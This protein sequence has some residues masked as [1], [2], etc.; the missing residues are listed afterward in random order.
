MCGDER[1]PSHGASLVAQPAS[2]RT[3]MK[4]LTIAAIT[5]TLMTGAA[6]AATDIGTITQVDPKRD[7]I[8][9]EDGKTFTLAEGTEA[10][11]L[12][13]GEKVIVTYSSKTGKLVATKIV[14]GK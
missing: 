5:V 13:V 2:R 12:K 4:S 11:S 9:L 1:R 14:V 8:T 3:R 6:F 7:A 10:E